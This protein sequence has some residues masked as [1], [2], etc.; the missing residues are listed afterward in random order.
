MLS[1]PGKQGFYYKQSYAPPLKRQVSQPPTLYS[2]LSYTNQLK[3]RESQK[4]QRSG[5]YYSR[6]RINTCSYIKQTGSDYVAVPFYDRNYPGYNPEFR[7]A[8]KPN[9]TTHQS[10]FKNLPQLHVGTHKKPLCKYS[11]QASR[12]RLLPDDFKSYYVN[13][14]VIDIG[15]RESQYKKQYVST[16]TNNYGKLRPLTPMTKNSAIFAYKCQ[17]EHKLRDQ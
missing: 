13:R 16:H 9:L 5:S 10:T 2:P 4:K 11:P 3:Y 14:S 7:F 8:S 17:W 15:D 12:S 6:T 1:M